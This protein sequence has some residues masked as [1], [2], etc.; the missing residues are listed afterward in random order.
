MFAFSAVL[1][2]EIVH[3][4]L[5]IDDFCAISK[6]QA[7][8]QKSSFS[9][10]FQFL[11]YFAD[12]PLFFENLAFP[13]TA[14]AVYFAETSLRRVTHRLDLFLSKRSAHEHRSRFCRGRCTASWST[15]PWAWRR[16]ACSSHERL[17]CEHTSALPFPGSASPPVCN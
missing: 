11:F 14:L 1:Q 12:F 15:A 10:I 9:R 3:F 6:N 8:L 5:K 16:V 2:G 7:F 17:L 4:P 13:R